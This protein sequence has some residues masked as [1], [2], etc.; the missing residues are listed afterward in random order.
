[1][2]LLLVL[3]N[4]LMLA[5]TAWANLTRD[6]SS[7]LMIAYGFNLVLYLVLVLP[8][9]FS[10]RP[11]VIGLTLGLHVAIYLIIAVGSAL[12]ASNASPTNPTAVAAE[13]RQ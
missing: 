1:M 13:V 5:A 7:A 12:Q 4:V 10:R 8:A 11:W 9:A 3:A 2:L 6:G